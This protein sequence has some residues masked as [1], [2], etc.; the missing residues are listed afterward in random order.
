MINQQNLELSRGFPRSSAPPR[1][2]RCAGGLRQ[3]LRCHRPKG[4]RPAL[5]KLGRCWRRLPRWSECL[6]TWNSGCGVSVSMLPSWCIL[7][8]HDMSICLWLSK[9]ESCWRQRM[10]SHL[11]VGCP[12]FLR[13]PRRLTMVPSLCFCSDFPCVVC[14]Q[15]CFQLS[16]ADSFHSFPV[17]QVLAFLA[18]WGNRHPKQHPP[19]TQPATHIMKG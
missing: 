4:P 1:R 15:A 18:G 14:S 2:P 5:P 11:L 3:P 9:E 8:Y 13:G 17:S 6:G 7:I 16:T 12:S 19:T 10:S